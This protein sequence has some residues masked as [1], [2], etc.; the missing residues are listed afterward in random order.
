MMK[1]PIIEI[2]SSFQGEGLLIGER[3]IFVRFAGC[4]LNCNYCDTDDSKSEKSGTLMTPQEVSEEI[5]KILTPD[6]KTI[7]FTGGEPS[8]YP[9]FISQVSKNFNL[10]IMLE[11]NGTLPDN[12]DLI[13]ELNIV[14]LDI[15]LPEHFDGDFD[16]SIFLNEIKSLNLLIAK[17]INVYCK[18]VIL[19][20][21]KIKSFK[22]VVEKLSQ[23]ISDK[24]DLKIIIQPSSPLSD[25]KD[26]NFRLFE[27]SEIVGQYF[28][29][30]TIPQIHKILDT[31]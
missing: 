31:E 7:S 27:F 12:I 6:C 16:E 19:P 21:T 20:S 22:E 26:I 8:L 1:A 23:N 4:N 14:S 28:E 30:S 25:W 5:E 13:D 18:V 2:F 15:K 24:S 29:V 10:K 3:Q 9:D 11:T 17:C